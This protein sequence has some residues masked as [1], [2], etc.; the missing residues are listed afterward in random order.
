MYHRHSGRISSSRTQVGLRPWPTL[1]NP[2]FHVAHAIDP[3]LIDTTAFP[4]SSHSRAEI[5]ELSETLNR[6]ARYLGLTRTDRFR[7]ANG[8]YMKLMNFRRFDPTFTEAGKVG[9]LR[10]GKAEEDV[11]N[12]FAGD[13]GR[14][15]QV[16]ETIRTVLAGSP[17]S[18]T[19]GELAVEEMEEAEEG[20]VITAMHRRFERNAAIVRI[21]KQRVLAQFGRL[22]C[23]ACGFDFRERYGERGENFIECHHTK[24]IHALK[25]GEKTRVADLRV[26]CSNCHRMVHAK[27]LWLSMEALTTILRTSRS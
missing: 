19:G 21:K 6:L 10:G 22:S 15:H 11:W 3:H 13:A 23:E 20:R 27:R 1:Y 26:L 9:L 17:E 16:A 4:R 5:V 18:E 24:P 14:C 12:K 8:V 2:D 7:N 25:A